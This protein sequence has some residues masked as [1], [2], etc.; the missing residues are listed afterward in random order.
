MSIPAS[1]V[2]AA[3]LAALPSVFPSL[4]TAQEATGT[5]D[6]TL[7][8]PAPADQTPAIVE[9]AE[10]FLATLSEE[11]REAVFFDW[12]DDAQ[13]ANWTN[14]PEGGSP[15]PRAGVRWGDLD[16]TQR[17]ALM[18]MLGTLLSFDGLRMVQEQMA[19]DDVVAANDTGP[20]GPPAG[21][22]PADA[23]DAPADAAEGEAA[24][25]E[26]PGEIASGELTEAAADEPADAANE[27]TEAEEDDNDG[28]PDGERP[29]VNFGSDWYFVS[30]LG[31]PSDTE[32]FMIQF[33]GHHLA[34]NATVVGPDVTLSP[35][36]TGGEPLK[37]TLN[38]R[39]VYIVEEE[40]VQAAQF[41]E[42][43]SEEQRGT[44]IVSDERVDLVLGPGHDGEVLQPEGIAGAD[45]D[46]QQR[47]QL[48]EL[49]EARLGILN[50]DDL[51]ALM[52]PI[53]GNLDETTFAWFGPT[54]PLGAAYWRVV[55]PTVI[56]E[57]SPQANDGDVTDHAHN[58]YRDPTNEYGAAWTSAE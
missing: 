56:L 44:A 9:V 50:A 46:I 33:G 57:F 55:G 52:E 45:L 49:V 14:F 51:A 24:S 11:Q 30:I 47:A 5:R 31:E 3:A 48:L 35:T 15:S 21:E 13:R 8:L 40:A 27:T 34:I 53:A 39:D 29:P 36:L 4:V 12:T 16:E 42:S 37:F 32:P 2:L 6:T 28:P 18:E 41:L 58:M 22:A 17:A 54:E 19:A 1:H 10:A 26:T 23:T 25:S 38:G 43:L 20:G 7:P